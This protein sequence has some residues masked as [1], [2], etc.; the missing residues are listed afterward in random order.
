M[1]KDSEWI[2]NRM[3]GYKESPKRRETGG[4]GLSGWVGGVTHIQS[5]W[6]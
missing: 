1:S 6:N 2:D 3:K 4:I 5:V